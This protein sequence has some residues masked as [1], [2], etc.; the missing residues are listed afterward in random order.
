M[1]FFDAVENDPDAPNLPNAVEAAALEASLNTRHHNALAQEE[2]QQVGQLPP[3]PAPEEIEPDNP[4]LNVNRHND[5]GTFHRRLGNRE[6][7]TLNEA[8]L[9]VHGRQQ[10]MARM[11]QLLDAPAAPPAAAPPVEEE[12]PPV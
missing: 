2:P 6:Q 1:N 7:V 9:S 3:P 5:D 11:A 10:A 8:H 12:A 4:N